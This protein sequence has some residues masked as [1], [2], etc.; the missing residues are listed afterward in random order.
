MGLLHSVNPT[1]GVATGL[2]YAR[3][4]PNLRYASRNMI[5]TELPV[6]TSIRPT[7]K[8]AIAGMMTRGSSWGHSIPSKSFMEKDKS[9]KSGRAPAI[10]AYMSRL[11]YARLTLPESPP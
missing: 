5:S 1:N 6:S 9:R 11:A 2:S 4:I 7:S 3:L 8:L 10:T